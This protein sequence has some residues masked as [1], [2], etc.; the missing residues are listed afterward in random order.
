MACAAGSAVLDEIGERGLVEHASII[1]ARIR[2][3]LEEIAAR[4]PLVGDV[5][6]RGLLL[7]IELV[8]DRS[9][10]AK[11]PVEV[12]PGALLVQRGLEHGL[13]LY[14]RRQNQG[15]FG[16]WLVVAP[17]LIIDESIADALVERL[18][19]VLASAIDELCVAA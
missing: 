1:G 2:S 4:S 15:R 14:S 6:G 17:P 16:D 10:S 9:T 12:D 18:G 8:A 5:R 7:A 11:F 19:A 13:L 3:G